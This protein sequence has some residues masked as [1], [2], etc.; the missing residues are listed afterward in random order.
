MS[1]NNINRDNLKINKN[2]YNTN[3][4]F[5]QRDPNFT[6]N[7][8]IPNPFK[9]ENNNNYRIFNINNNMNYINYYFHQKNDIIYQKP[10]NN[11]SFNTNNNN[12]INFDNEI[13]AQKSSLENMVNMGKSSTFENNPNSFFLDKKVMIIS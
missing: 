1:I 12:V 9:I 7:N 5:N 2:L 3:N 10:I 4:L 11:M 8:I 13:L 6:N